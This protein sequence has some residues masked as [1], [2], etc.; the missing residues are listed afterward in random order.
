[1]LKEKM[2]VPE[3]WPSS[4]PL[5]S[6]PNV[7]LSA[8][9]SEGLRDSMKHFMFVLDPSVPRGVDPGGGGGS[10][11]PPPPP[12]ISTTWKNNDYVMQE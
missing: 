9:S 4:Y 1:M 11:C 7:K 3:S 12:I 5:N 8:G 6:N 10:R 2:F